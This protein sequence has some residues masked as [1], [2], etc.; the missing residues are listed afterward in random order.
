[1]PQ[2]HAT[3]HALS[4]TPFLGTEM[5]QLTVLKTSRRHHT[6][7]FLDLALGNAGNWLRIQGN[8]NIRVELQ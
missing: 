7:I 2:H 3:H 1:M 8:P 6:G 4:E 5:P